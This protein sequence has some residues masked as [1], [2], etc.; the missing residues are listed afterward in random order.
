MATYVYEYLSVSEPYSLYTSAEMS[1]GLILDPAKSTFL[2]SVPA[3]KH[4]YLWGQI[5][6]KY[7]RFMYWNLFK[8]KKK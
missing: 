1:H 4:K 2:V 6:A 3:Y 5:P 7:W 8:T